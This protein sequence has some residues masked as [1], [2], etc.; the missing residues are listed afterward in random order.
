MPVLSDQERMI[1]DSAATFFERAGGLARTRRTRDEGAPIDRGLWKDAAGQG[2]LGML[3]REEAGG[4]DFGVRDALVMLRAAAR[5][6]PFEPFSA[7][8]AAARCM[9]RCVGGHP[10]LADLLSGREIVVPV[11]AERIAG[12]PG[13]LAGSTRPTPD[14]AAADRFLLVC[15]S[16]AGTRLFLVGREDS[17]LSFH[18]S[19]TR[20][21]GSLGTLRLHKVRAE[22]IADGNGAEEAAVDLNDLLCL[23]RAAELLGLAQQAF[24]ETLD[25]L[26]TRRQFGVPLAS[27]QALQHRAASLYVALSADDALLFEAAGAWGGPRQSFAALAAIARTSQTASNVCKQAVQMHGAIGFTEEHSIGLYLKRAMALSAAERGRD[28]LSG[29]AAHARARRRRAAAAD[30]H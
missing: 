26:R 29:Q 27:F 28:T 5:T 4:L 2:W 1:E 21:G 3:V 14:L 17:G 9:A 25:Y 13:A 30:M 23:F 24:A 7:T 10:L 22:L 19:G 16:D 20:D 18:A 6:V 15:S 8:I 12:A 11:F